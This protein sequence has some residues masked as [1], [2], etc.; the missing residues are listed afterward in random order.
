MP[1]I[2]N[3]GIRVLPND[4]VAN[5]LPRCEEVFN[6][7]RRGNRKEVSADI[8]VNCNVERYPLRKQPP[9]E[10]FAVPGGV[11]HFLD[12]KS[13]VFAVDDPPVE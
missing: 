8:F 1:I 3:S 7:S 13:D 11:G 6:K 2:G 12:K 5:Q 9:S 4:D 10:I